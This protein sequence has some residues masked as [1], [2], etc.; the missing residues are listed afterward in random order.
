MR[1]ECKSA[2]VKNGRVRLGDRARVWGVDDYGRDALL[3]GT[4][5]RIKRRSDRRIGTLVYIEIAD[6]DGEYLWWGR[7][8]EFEKVLKG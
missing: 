2:K 5:V 8:Y 3:T 7:A 1:R 6:E 4:V